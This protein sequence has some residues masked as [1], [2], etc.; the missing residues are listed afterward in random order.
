MY[1]RTVVPSIQ[2][3]E[4]DIRQGLGK[5]LAEEYIARAAIAKY[6]L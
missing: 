5:G 6:P 1:L 4:K 2:S 3:A